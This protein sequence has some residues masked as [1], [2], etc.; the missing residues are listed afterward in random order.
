[1]HAEVDFIHTAAVPIPQK[2]SGM[3]VGNE[4]KRI[5]P[6]SHKQRQH[7]FAACSLRNFYFS[8]LPQLTDLLIP[9]VCVSVALFCRPQ[10]DPRGFQSEIIAECGISAHKECPTCE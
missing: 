10:Y 8:P 5:D 2:L 9:R 3:R 1:L 7:F 4:L 6:I